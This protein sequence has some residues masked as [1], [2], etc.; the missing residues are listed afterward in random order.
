VKRVPCIGAV[1]VFGEPFKFT[2]N[3]HRKTNLMVFLKTHIIKSARDIESITSTK[4]NTIRPLYEQAV[5]GGTILFPKKER[6]MPED[7]QPSLK[8]DKPAVVAPST[9]TSQ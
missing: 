6:H 7:L 2:E 5:E 3:T 4:Y 9:G 1:P 8:M